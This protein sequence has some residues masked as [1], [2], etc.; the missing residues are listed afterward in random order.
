MVE[1]QT[2]YNDVAQQ[3]QHYI[4]TPARLDSLLVYKPLYSATAKRPQDA[5]TES[6]SSPVVDAKRPRRERDSLFQALADMVGFHFS[7]RRF[8]EEKEAKYR[9]AERLEASKAILKEHRLRPLSTIEDDLVNQEK[10]SVLT[11]LALCAIE[12]FSVIVLDGPKFYELS[13]DTVSVPQVVSRSAESGGGF[14]LEREADETRIHFIRAN[15]AAMQTVDTT[16]KP[17][18]SYKID[19]LMQM[20]NKFGLVA[21]TDKR[22]LKKEYYDALVAYFA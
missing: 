19:E 7:E 12:G 6:R 11:F 14:R 1:I 13:L 5:T 16:L 8:L 3:L 18:G 22:K 4:L 2:S 15:F 20:C 17:I 9:Y 21:A 10:I